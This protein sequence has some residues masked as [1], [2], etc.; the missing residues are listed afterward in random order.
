VIAVVF[1]TADALA[2]RIAKPP[3]TAAADFRATDL[4]FFSG[5]L[6]FIFGNHKR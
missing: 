4:R 1:I 5:K 2:E 6:F 3:G